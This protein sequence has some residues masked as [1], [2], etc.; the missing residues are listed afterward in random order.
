MKT[1]MIPG[2]VRCLV[3]LA[4]LTAAGAPTTV[5]AP[6]PLTIERTD[7]N[8]LKL[9]FD[10]EGG[11]VYRLLGAPNFTDGWT[12]AESFTNTTGS[13]ETFVFPTGTTRFFRAVREAPVG[14][15]V[16][17]RNGDVLSNVVS[18]SA[19]VFSTAAPL[20]G[21]VLLDIYAGRTNLLQWSYGREETNLTF[22]I[23]TALI[24]TGEHLFQLRVADENGPASGEL[25]NIEYTAPVRV[26]VLNPLYF[27]G[28]EYNSPEVSW[29]LIV[30]F[31]TTEREGTWRTDVYTDTGT[32]WATAGGDIASSKGADGLIVVE[33]AYVDDGSGPRPR[34]WYDEYP[35][36]FFDVVVSVTPAGQLT[37]L[38]NLA[39]AET[40][41]KEIRKR[42]K[43]RRPR[44]YIIC[45]DGTLLREDALRATMDAMMDIPFVGMFALGPHFS[46][47]TMA[48]DYDV[49]PSAEGWNILRTRTAWDNLNRFLA[50]ATN[51]TYRDPVQ[52]THLYSISHGGVKGIGGPAGGVSSQTLQDSGYW[53]CTEVTVKGTGQDPQ[54]YMRYTRTKGLTFVFLDGCSTMEGDLVPALLNG[55]INA[56]ENGQ[57]T[58]ID[59]VT[60][61]QFPHYGCGWTRK[62]I[63]SSVFRT[64]I[65]FGHADYVKQFFGSLLTPDPE[66][67]LPANTYRQARSRA[68]YWS[69]SPTFVNPASQG[70]GHTGCDELYIDE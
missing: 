29:K 45:E 69:N 22:T 66:T 35:Y 25:A 7:T 13:I 28:D 70:W 11:G 55:P 68:R 64:D 39:A 1:S 20:A 52:G 10:A 40:K 12:V 6:I 19:S 23:D 14:G 37:P 42:I 58:I 62:K 67:G 34:T 16:F 31:G 63:F 54:T 53:E 18:V 43:G 32:H 46:L 8:A 59:L 21:T 57:V 26:R 41:T 9:R 5:G 48:R 44:T 2:T 51:E 56:G 33:D 49:S 4:V 50:G 65:D 24:E 3:G 38:K 61:G 47:Q 15:T 30:R 36:E 27:P 17:L 60:K